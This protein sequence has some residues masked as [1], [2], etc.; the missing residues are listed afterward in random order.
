MNKRPKR[1]TTGKGGGRGTCINGTSF[2]LIARFFY[3]F[4]GGVGGVAQRKKYEVSV[5][6]FLKQ[7]LSRFSRPNCVLMQATEKM[8]GGC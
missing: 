5:Q 4:L 6:A 2:A 1:Q 7:K 8:L 3:P